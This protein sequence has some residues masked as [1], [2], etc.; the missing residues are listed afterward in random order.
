MLKPEK[1]FLVINRGLC[2]CDYL[3]YLKFSRIVLTKGLAECNLRFFLGIEIEK[4]AAEVLLEVKT[5][6][7]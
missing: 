2:W 1:H 3:K 5:Q 4:M 6:N 7:Y